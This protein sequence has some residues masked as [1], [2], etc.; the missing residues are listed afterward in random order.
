MPS[1]TS[2]PLICPRDIQARGLNDPLSP[3]RM[4]AGWFLNIRDVRLWYLANFD[5]TRAEG[6]LH[7]LNLLRG[8]DVAHWHKPDQNQCPLSCRCWGAKRTS[9]K[10]AQQARYVASLLIPYPRALSRSDL[11]Q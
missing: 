3:L 2:L 10:R 1:I 9:S 6:R 5:C 7:N 8:I 4:T 11:V